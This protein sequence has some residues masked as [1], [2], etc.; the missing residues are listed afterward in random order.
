MSEQVASLC[1][2]C[3]HA[4]WDR[5]SNGRRHPNGN[6]KCGYQFPDGP[7]PKW[8]RQQMWGRDAAAITTL[9]R[10]LEKHAT[11]RWISWMDHHRTEPEACPTWEAK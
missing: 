5:T 1:Q 2:S 8:V 6:G 10:L 11:G 9:A 4:E 3:K 7:L